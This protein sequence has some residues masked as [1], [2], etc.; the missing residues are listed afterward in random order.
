LFIPSADDFILP[1]FFEKSLRLL[2]AHPEA[3]LSFAYGSQFDGATGKVRPQATDLSSEP[4]YLPPREMAAR[5]RG[6][7][8]GH[9]VIIKRA[10]FAEAGGCR[11]E[12]KGACD[13]FVNHVV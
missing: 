12:L 13:L 11:A 9:T 5:F 3:G 10:A 8:P 7:I 2:A 4:C 6:C 1:G